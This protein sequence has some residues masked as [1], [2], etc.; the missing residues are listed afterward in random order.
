MS[1]LWG[2]AT[3]LS[4]CAILTRKLAQSSLVCVLNVCRRQETF[5]HVPLQ[6]DRS[7]A[8]SVDAQLQKK[9]YTKKWQLGNLL[10]TT[11]FRGTLSDLSWALSSNFF[12]EGVHLYFKDLKLYL[13]IVSLWINMTKGKK[14]LV[15]ISFRPEWRQKEDYRGNTKEIIQIINILL[16]HFFQFHHFYTL[17]F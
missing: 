8:L 16:I 3:C 5:L 17:I 7:C 11:Y 4:V 12:R 1:E 15:N 2:T 6:A 13:K 9:N 10:G 14:K